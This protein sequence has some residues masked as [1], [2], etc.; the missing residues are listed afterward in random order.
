MIIPSA[1]PF[2]YP[3][4]EIG[5]LLIHGFT[6]TPKEMRWMGE[7]LAEQD[8]S[9]L[10]VRLAGHAT[11]LD[12]LNHAYWQDWI[13]SVEDGYHLLK[14]MC[15]DIFVMGLSMGGV[16]AL[17]LAAHFPV[18][19]VVA[20]STPYAV[21]PDPRSRFIRPL[22]MFIR[23]IPKGPPDWHNQEAAV[24][25]I[26][27]P[28]YPTKG[29]IQLDTLLSELRPVLSKIKVP[30]LLIHSHTDQ[31]VAPENMNK[32]YDA[33]GSEE[34]SMIWLDDSGHV[35]TREPEREIVF[36]AVAEFIEQH[37]ANVL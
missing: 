23:N 37:A 6:G 34:K 7:Y 4:S 33:L 29:I 3:G 20:M 5:C 14:G 36:R 21:P 13:A 30:V 1:E 10:G 32:I 18:T 15:K 19:G 16:L 26:D 17:Y 22:G 12:D 2:L 25:H 11:K 24:D 8:Y 31:G 35:I 9:V 27:Y 28:A